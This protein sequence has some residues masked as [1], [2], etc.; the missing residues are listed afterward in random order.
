MKL[1][2]RI[3][4]LLLLLLFFTPLI[5]SQVK[6]KEIKEAT[7]T[8][9]RKMPASKKVAQPSKTQE[10]IQQEKSPVATTPAAKPVVTSVPVAS[11]PAQTVVQP[12]SSDKLDTIIKLGGKK[13]I[14]IVKK[15]NPT[16]VQYTKP[17]SSALLEIPR[18]DIEKI[19]YKT[20]RREEF[21]KPIFSI[22]DDKQW[23]AVMVTE[24]ESDVQGLY[25]I[26]VVKANASAGSRSP[27]AAKQSATI[28]LQKKTANLG[29]LIVLVVSSESKGGYGEIPGW[30]LEGIAYSDS[31][32]SD[33]AAVNKAIRQMMARNKERIETAKT[34]K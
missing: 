9:K 30:Q 25:R 18:K 15:V 22:I 23:E 27:K 7:V 31:P 16:A 5:I 4:I 29:A 13:I 11:P 6:N 34:K 33:T 3:S 12:T 1:M 14:C 10:K 2:R 21:N 32:P 26:G 24:K 20:G 28:R 8:Y 19:L 17:N